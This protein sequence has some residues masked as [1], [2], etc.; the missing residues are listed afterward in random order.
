MIVGAEKLGA[1]DADSAITE[2]RA[3]GGAGNKTDVLG[4]GL[5]V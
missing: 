3:F 5:I 1:F 2:R 4:H